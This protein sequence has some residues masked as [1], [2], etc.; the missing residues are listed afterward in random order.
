VYALDEAGAQGPEASSDAVV[1]VLFSAFVVVG[2]VSGPSEAD[3]FRGRLHL[4]C[5]SS[6]P[7][8]DSDSPRVSAM[9]AKER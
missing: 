7:I 4:L 1:M 5:P 3:V 6:L 2:A 8:I 9:L